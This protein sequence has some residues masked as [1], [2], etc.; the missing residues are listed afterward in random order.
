MSNT[1]ITY[2]IGETAGV[3][4]STT[5]I[6]IDLSGFKFTNVIISAGSEDVYYAFAN[7]GSLDT[8]SATLTS[9]PED[10]KAKMVLA[11]SSLM[12]PRDGTTL[13]VA[14]ASGTSDCKVQDVQP[15]RS[16]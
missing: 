10:S 12:V 13:R 3:Q 1:F 9:T 5:E 8:L 14:T 11:N 6:N 7:S 16:Q 2:R 15:E 4:A